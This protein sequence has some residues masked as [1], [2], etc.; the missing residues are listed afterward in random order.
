MDIR[1]PGLEKVDYNR[2]EKQRR[3]GFSGSQKTARGIYAVLS[4]SCRKAR[5]GLGLRFAK[6]NRK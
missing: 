2:Q 5:E 4:F 1:K 6:V 3:Q